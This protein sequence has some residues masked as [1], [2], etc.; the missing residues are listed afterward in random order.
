MDVGFLGL[1]AMGLPM[2]GNLAAAG[3]RVLAWNRS[4]IES[5]PAVEL[6][7]SPAEVAAAPVTF[8]MVTDEAA[9]REVVLGED[10]WLA[11]AG[12][13]Q[14]LVQSSTIGPEATRRLAADVADHGVRL[15]D[16]PVSG[17][18]KP[19]E[20]GAL[21]FLV[22]G[23]KGDLATLAPFFDAMGK[24]AVHCGPV[25]AGA[26]VKLAINATLVSV[27]AAAA[28]A[29]TWLADTEP[30]VPPDVVE[31]VFQRIS[32][33][34][35]QR[36]GALTGEPPAGGFSLRQVAKDMGLVRAAMAPAEVLEAVSTTAQSALEAGFGDHDI[37][38]L[39]KAAR[40]RR[41]G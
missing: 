40:R 15:V 23:E 26:A 18:V 27:V 24:A 41:S 29:L 7:K 39:G 13:G 32:P 17:S 31:T 6:V 9:V 1:G 28:E 35:A 19:A 14:M 12:A 37:S 25:G 30:A 22:G 4:S 10:G 21:T 8:I 3:H 38:A 20:Q 2:A 36:A 34:V 33:L 5:P 16:A 11:G